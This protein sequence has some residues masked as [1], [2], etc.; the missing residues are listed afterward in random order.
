MKK[1]IKDLWVKALKSGEF[2]QIQG[3]LEKDGKYCALGIL[4]VL[5]LVNG[6]CTYDERSDGGRFDNR[7]STLSYNVMNWA[8]IKNFL[9]PGAGVVKFMHK[10]KGRSI[11]E[12]NDHGSDFNEIARVIEK[13]WKEL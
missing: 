4:W 3:Q 12:M 2:N 13:K 1:N 9:D 7:R 5:A 8:G 11:S 10:G 6:I